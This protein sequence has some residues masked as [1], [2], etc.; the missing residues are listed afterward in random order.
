MPGVLAN[1]AQDVLKVLVKVKEIR[2]NGL[3]RAYSVDS[4]VPDSN[5]WKHSVNHK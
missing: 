1:G 4:G 3:N 5:H 2:S